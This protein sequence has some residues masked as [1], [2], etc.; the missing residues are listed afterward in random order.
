MIGKTISHYR[1][2]QKLGEGGMGVV[3]RAEDISLGRSV[4]L[5]FL[6]PEA[7]MGEEGQAR[8]AREARSAAALNHPSVC[9][10]Y[11]MDRAEGRT[12]IAMECVEGQ[13]LK[14]V[15][16]SGPL[17]LDEAIDIG[18]QIAEG[19]EEA[20]ARGIIHRD[21]KPANIMV[22]PAGQAKIMDFGLAKPFGATKLTRTGA[23]IGTVA[24]MSP[25]QARGSDVDARS[26]I[27]SL[28]AVLYEM[29]AG[30]PP[31]KGDY[32][33]AVI[34][35]ILNENPE[36]VTALRPDAPAELARI[37]GKALA[38]KRADRYPRAEDLL[39]DLESL[40]RSRGP[41]AAGGEATSGE[42][43]PSIAVLPFRD[44]SSGRDQEYFCE[45]IAEELINAL[46]KLEGLGV[47]ARTSSFRFK[48]RDSDIK[49]IGAQLGV[50]TVLEGSVRKSGDRL[51]VTAQ[52]VNVEDGFHLWSE[53]YD[54]DLED[55]FAIQDEISLA[56]VEKLRVRLLGG[57][58]R[59]LVKRY[60]ADKDAHNLYLK[61]LYFW[62]RRLEGGMKMAMEHFRQAID[63]DPG[64]ALAYVGIAD[65]Y[66]STG[67]LG[68]LPPKETL[69]KAREAA[70]K[71][72][73]IDEALGEAHASLAF[74]NAFF[75]WDW[76]AAEAGFK[77]AIQLNPSYAT[78]HQWYGFFLALTG[79][80][81]EGITES[82]KARDLDPLSPLIN[83]LTAASYYLAG[84]YEE[85]IAIL[86]KTLELAPNF[87]PANGYIAMVYVAS[88]MCEDAVEAIR[89]FEASAA[90][91]AYTLGHM[92]Y[93]YGVCGR[94][95]DALRVLG[96]L[97]ELAKQRYV[98]P[99][100]RAP[101]LLGL[102]RLDEAFDLLEEAYMERNPWLL[103]CRTVPVYKPLLSDR[104]Y[105]ELLTKIGFEG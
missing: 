48:D 2:L 43:K 16:E 47:A 82:E 49:T 32:E 64:Y 75:D 72:L 81:D 105:K 69:P 5:K 28:G 73:E 10:I 23:T 71:A 56:I 91:H 45:G 100:H 15:I 14:K 3:Y 9:T 59:A 85:S 51:R 52:L 42:S 67:F 102:D 83:T 33:Q 17:E 78:A 84:R 55:I 35:R 90:G 29:V 63:K 89:R 13:S 79:R 53:K 22:T 68:Y 11:E 41:R 58:R 86:L 62:N 101:V 21:I 31:F 40:R 25:E 18:I 60:T 1:I 94:R 7:V 98:S 30:Q 80:F 37:L 99:V 27:W 36:P 74:I 57:E 103:F 39:S 44:M 34:Y 93:A 88:G 8:L 24:Y 70:R 4:A 97:D 50:R 61:G 12:F 65:T 66:S 76:A 95:D 92:G 87:L 46:V 20:H 38:G 19:L 96:L 54:R 6:A 77:R 26:D 104:R